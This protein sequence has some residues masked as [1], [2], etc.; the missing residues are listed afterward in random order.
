MNLAKLLKNYRLVKSADKTIVRKFHSRVKENFCLVK[1]TKDFT[2]DG[3]NFYEGNIY[4]KFE[5]KLY[6]L[7]GDWHARGIGH[8]GSILTNHAVLDIGIRGWNVYERYIRGCTKV[9]NESF[10]FGFLYHKE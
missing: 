6:D 3:L 1:C 5:D 10:F 9:I 8:Q 2:Q 4:G 7:Q